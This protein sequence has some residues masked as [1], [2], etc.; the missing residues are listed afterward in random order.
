LALLTKLTGLLAIGAGGVAYLIHGIQS[1]DKVTALRRALVF[2]LAAILVGGWFYAWMLFT[3]GY[4][5]PHGLEVHSVMFRMPPGVR[6][7]SDYLWI[8]WQTFTELHLLSPKLL[9][10]VWGSTY[11]TIW[12]DGHHHFLPSSGSAIAKVGTA[13]L[14]LG[15]VPTVAFAVGLG[16]GARRL[17]QGVRGPDVVLMLLVVAMV[18]GYVLFTWRNPWFAVLKGSFLLGLSVPFSYYASE[19]LADWTRDRGLR[20]KAVLV[21][22][23]LLA[24]LVT[25][26]FAYGLTFEK[27]EMPGV[28]WTPVETPWQK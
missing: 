19:V 11:I 13:L 1:D 3:Y 5:Y 18:A 22:L 27:H 23:G 7:V 24:A 17:L 14:L 20:S 15:L 21:C 8:P 16:R 26:T 9:H 12:F 28:Q 2:S 4:L 6:S 25:V 10:S